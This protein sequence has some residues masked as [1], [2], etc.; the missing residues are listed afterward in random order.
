MPTCAAN[1]LHNLLTPPRQTRAL[2]FRLS[3]RSLYTV[4]LSIYER[5]R[6]AVLATVSLL[7]IVIVRTSSGNSSDATPTTVTTTTVPPVIEQVIPESVIL[8]GP[9]PLAPTGS[10]V[11]A[12][13]ADTGNSIDGRAS[14][15]NLGYTQTPICYSIEAPIGVDLTITNVNNGRS[16]KCTNV[17][18]LLVPAG[19]TVILHTTVF[20]RLADLIDAPIPVKISW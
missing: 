11:I 20:T 14:F 6:I 2:R 8:G 10:A 4:A 5:R 3:L 1:P 13:P 17:Y 7:A 9:A 12:Y 15:S 16:V 18:S 19:I